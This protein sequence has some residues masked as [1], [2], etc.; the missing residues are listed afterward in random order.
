[1]MMASVSG[2]SSHK[3]N[4]K[5]S[6]IQKCVTGSEFTQQRVH[7]HHSYG[8]GKSTG[9]ILMVPKKINNHW[10]TVLQGTLKLLLFYFMAD[11]KQTLMTN[12]KDNQNWKQK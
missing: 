2:V 3:K 12:V 1:M 4:E 5:I 7:T 9:L 11:Q 8:S 6:Q 10:N